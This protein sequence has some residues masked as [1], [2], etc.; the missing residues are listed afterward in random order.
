MPGSFASGSERMSME[1]YARI[2]VRGATRASVETAWTLVTD[3]PAQSRWIAFTRVF[4]VHHTDGVGARFTGRTQVGP[5][6]FDDRME[7]M[8]WEPPAGAQRGYCKVRKLGP[9]IFGTAEIEVG[10]SNGGRDE[11][12][13]TWK[14]TVRLR[15]V[16][17]AF[18]PLVRAMGGILFRMTMRKAIAE[19]DAM[20][21]SSRRS[22]GEF[23]SA[24]P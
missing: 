11:T 23:D 6:G 9:W 1:Q 16:P 18:N 22:S 10:S 12:A 13:V 14:E 5:I 19:L 8:I 15:G 4:I 24:S 21:G 2:I 20:S 3:W 7:V 17:P